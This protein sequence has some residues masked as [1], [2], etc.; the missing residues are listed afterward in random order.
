MSTTRDAR[1][2][3]LLA[4]RATEGLDA[5]AQRE[6]SGLLRERPEVDADGF[7]L[8]AAALYL[9]VASA[10]EEAPPNLRSGLERQGRAWL[11]SRHG[12]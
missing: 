7:D 11:E 9:A 12:S 4:D 6:L 3:D 1:L 5:V 2:L 8:A 10:S